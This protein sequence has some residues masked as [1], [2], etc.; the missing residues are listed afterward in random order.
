[1][2]FLKKKWVDIN[3]N[4]SIP[5]GDDSMHFISCLKPLCRE[6]L[7][8]KLISLKPGSQYDAGAM[9]V[10]SVV[11]VTGKSIFSPVKL[12]PWH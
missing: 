11:S 12:H 2:G 9:S 10:T 6:T 7:F 3:S 4:D 5:F 8:D 1:M